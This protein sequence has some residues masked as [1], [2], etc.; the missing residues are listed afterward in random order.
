MGVKTGLKPQQGIQKMVF[1]L[2]GGVLAQV[3]QLGTENCSDFRLSQY[4]LGILYL[5]KNSISTLN[6]YWKR[7]ITP[8]NVYLDSSRL[9]WHHFG[10][11]QGAGPHLAV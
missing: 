8:E 1:P 10:P 7:K 11:N 2:P 6:D 5:E 9:A 4:L 3:V